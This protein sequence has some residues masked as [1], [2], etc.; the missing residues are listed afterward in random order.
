MTS[1]FAVILKRT[2]MSLALI[3]VLAF[4]TVVLVPAMHRGPRIGAVCQDGWRSSA[5]GRGACSHHGGVAYWV[6]AERPGPL[7]TLQRPILILGVSSTAGSILLALVLSWRRRRGDSLDSGY[8]S[9]ATPS[10]SPSQETP[11]HKDQ[12]ELG[13]CPLCNNSLVKRVRKRDGHPFLGCSAFPRC[14]YTRNIDE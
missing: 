4:G 12:G 11:L 3:A 5:T 6:H 7:K 9:R 8:H 10:V 13:L 14:G 2:A 1:I